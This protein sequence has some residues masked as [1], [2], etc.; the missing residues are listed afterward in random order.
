MYNRQ[1]KRIRSIAF[2]AFALVLILFSS[3]ASAASG[4]PSVK[5]AKITLEESEF[6]YNGQAHT[7]GVSVKYKKELLTEGV[8][9][10][11]SYGDNTDAGKASVKIK[12]IGKYQGKAQK[13]FVIK[14]AEN[15]VYAEDILLAYDAGKREI[16]YEAEQKGDGKLSCK[17]GSSSVTVTKNG[18][19]KIKAGFT[20]VVNLTVTASASKNYKKASAKIRLTVMPEQPEITRIFAGTNKNAEVEWKECGGATGYELEILSRDGKDAV[21]QIPISGKKKTSL[22]I[23]APNGPGNYR[24]CIRSVYAKNKKAVC[25]S[26]WTVPEPLDIPL[27]IVMTGSDYQK[28]ENVNPKYIFPVLL[29]AFENYGITPD[30]VLMCGD[31]SH[32]G[33]DYGASVVKYLEQI[34]V[35]LEDVFMGFKPRDSLVFVQGNHDKDEGDFAEDGLHD[36]GPCLVYVINTQTSNPWSQGA[37]GEAARKKIENTALQ[38]ENVFKGLIDSGEKRPVFVATHVPLHFSKWTAEAGDN[39]YSDALFRVLQEAGKKLDIVFLYGHNHGGHGDSSIGGGS[40]FL[41]PGESILI[42][43]R[44]ADEQTTEEFASHQLT[45]AYM[46]AGYLGYL[47]KNPAGE[48]ST[49]GLI[50]LYEDRMEFKRIGW[51]GNEISKWS[52]L[53]EK[54]VKTY[55]LLPDDY[56]S[57]KRETYMLKRK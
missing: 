53:S 31:Y 43:V 7:P 22:S 23:D 2:I 1:E 16:A 5:N 4:L 3:A 50:F 17:S 48:R 12:G 37:V 30:L 54:G 13:Q 57:V 46:N 15:E 47:V 25:H 14:R 6:V 24:I 28:D 56:L 8:D 41:A 20:G 32:Q 52:N 39:L 10:E 51:Y 49:C 42:P 33:A 35:Y 18:T 36:C 21:R 44:E 40:S 19:L 34:T 45:F 38:M 11:L 55:K 26:E 29:G 9:Y 27:A